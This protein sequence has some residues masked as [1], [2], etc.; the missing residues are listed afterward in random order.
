M[1]ATD[2][3]FDDLLVLASRGELRSGLPVT[4]S[5]VT[6]PLSEDDL[7]RLSEAAD[8]AEAAGFE[9]AI[10]VLDRRHL[11]LEVSTRRIIDEPESEG[12]TRTIR[13]DGAVLAPSRVEAPGLLQGPRA[14]P[15]GPILDQIE[16][17]RRSHG[18]SSQPDET[19]KGVASDGST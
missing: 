14:L 17:A 7:A 15:P 5:A 4:P 11:I 18:A 8:T 19:P 2:G 3:A 12:S 1:A 16:T 9:R 10:V 6:G 13:V